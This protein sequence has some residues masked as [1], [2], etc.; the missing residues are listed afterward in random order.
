[1]GPRMGDEVTIHAHHPL[2]F[3]RAYVNRFAIFTFD[4]SCG[5]EGFSIIINDEVM[6]LNITLDVYSEIYSASSRAYL[7]EEVVPSGS[8]TDIITGLPAELHVHVS[9]DIPPGQSDFAF[10]IEYT[11]GVETP[12]LLELP[13]LGAGYWRP[14]TSEV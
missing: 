4:E 2:A 1:M 8:C 10:I 5:F 12:T 14:T 9:I 11:T 6:G 3:P 7:L 13:V